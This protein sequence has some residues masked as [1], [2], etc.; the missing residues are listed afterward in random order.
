MNCRD[1]LEGLADY[2]DEDAR[3][4]ICKQIERHMSEC[5]DCR[6]YV[7]TLKGTVA[8]VRDVGGS[9]R[10]CESVVVRLKTRILRVPEA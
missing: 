6:V 1:L 2:L 9:G 5:P 3:A 10:C 4:E 8:L 7:D